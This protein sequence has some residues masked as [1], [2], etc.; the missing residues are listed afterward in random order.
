MLVKPLQAYQLLNSNIQIM[1]AI[2][3]YRIIDDKRFSRKMTLSQISFNVQTNMQGF[4]LDHKMKRQRGTRTNNSGISFLFFTW[5]VYV[6][7]E[8]HIS[9][10]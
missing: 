1:T 10:K 8:D 3:Y 7:H 5:K 9:T 2:K 4:L 6:G